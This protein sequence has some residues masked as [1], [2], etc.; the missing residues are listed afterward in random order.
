MFTT[1]QEYYDYLYECIDD[2]PQEIR[3]STF[4]I[5]A[6]ILDTGKSMHSIGGKYLSKVHNFLDA[7]EEKTDRVK[8]LVGL[9]MYRSCKG[10]HEV[11][12]HCITSYAKI[13]SR[14]AKH[15]ENWPSFQWRFHGELHLKCAI[16][17]YDNNKARTI[18]GGRNF[19]D[20]DWAD[21][22][23]ALQQKQIPRLKKFYD[24]LWKQSEEVTDENLSNF[25][26]DKFKDYLPQ[27]S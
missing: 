9:P 3:I 7:V 17:D 18:V 20:S 1:L 5:Y 24:N 2:Q 19:T 6:G 11:C 16:F 12:K 15:Q 25:L 27:E 22:S 21:I 10:K 26:E 8:I 13:Y 4:G 23:F 14:L